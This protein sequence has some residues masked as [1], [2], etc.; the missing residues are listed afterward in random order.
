MSHF[1]PD[2]RAATP[3]AQAEQLA[4][5]LDAARRDHSRSGQHYLTGVPTM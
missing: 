5:E 1:K 2:R 3:Q 4:A